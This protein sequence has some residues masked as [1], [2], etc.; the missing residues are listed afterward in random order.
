MFYHLTYFLYEMKPFGL[1]FYNM[2]LLVS[3][4]YNPYQL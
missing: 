1:S 3:S 2:T 4:V